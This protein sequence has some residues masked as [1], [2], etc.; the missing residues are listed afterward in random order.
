MKNKES[1]ISNI[2]KLGKGLFYAIIALSVLAVVGVVKD[3]FSKVA[4]YLGL[5]SKEKKE[6][7][8]KLTDEL[9]ADG[10]KIKADAL[11]I[12]EAF[13]VN[14]SMFNPF[15]WT[16]DEQAAYDVLVKYRKA[17]FKKLSSMYYLLTDNRDLMEDI[18]SYMNDAQASVIKNNVL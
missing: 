3:V 8:N 10:E 7:V 14:Y 18:I 6:K 1:I 13:G 4:S 15:G 5:D 17:S 16:E 12:V 9:G 11:T 2:M